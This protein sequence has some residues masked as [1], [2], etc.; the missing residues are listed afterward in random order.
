MLIKDLIA[1]RSR[2]AKS[3][4]IR[5]I[6]RSNVEHAAAVHLTSDLEAAE[7]RR[8]GWK[9]PLLSVLPNGI[10]PPLAGGGEISA[11][12]RAIAGRRPLVLFFGRLSWKKGLDRL[13]A[14]I[15]RSPTA[16]CAIV[17]PDDE[18][19]APRLTQEAVRLGISERVFILPRSVVGQD[20][21]YLYAAAQVFVLPSYSENFGNTVLEALRRGVPAVVTPEVGAAEVVLAS[22][23]G[24]ITAGEPELLAAAI[25]KL[26]SNRELAQ[27]LGEAGK[28]HVSAHYTW[29]DIASRMLELYERLRSA[30]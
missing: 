19:L 20:K 27:A 21:E 17:G 23:G 4:W 3:T 18:G 14:A 28:R 24:I 11:D 9:L 25:C 16:Q 29:P 7:L 22:G 15:A 13:V 2:F 12:V 30:H 6:E 26:I 8:F 10:E 1:R 5:F